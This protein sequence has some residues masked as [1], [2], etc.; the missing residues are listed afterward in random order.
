MEAKKPSFFSSV[1]SGIKGFIKGSL[2]GGVVGIVAG[3]AVATV[4]ALIAPE[5]SLEVLKVS[6]PGALGTIGT[7][8]TAAVSGAFSGAGLF[9]LIGGYS[10]MATEVVKSREAGQVTAQD[11]V[12]VAKL[13]YAQGIGVGHQIAQ[14]QEAETGSTK[15]RDKIAKERA[16]AAQQTQ[17]LH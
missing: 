2:A 6:A 11:V 17:Q 14:A 15:F 10:G 7:V 9:G 1:M 12:G 13:S 16:Q 3:A 8:G 5:A 4:L